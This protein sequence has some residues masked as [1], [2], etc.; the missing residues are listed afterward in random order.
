MIWSNARKITFRD[1]KAHLIGTVYETDAKRQLRRPLLDA[2]DVHKS[3]VNYGTVPETEEEHS[4]VVK[5]YKDIL[6]L[7]DEAFEAIP[8]KV[9]RHA[10]VK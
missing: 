8:A 6:D 3:N 10:E 1:V 5:W 2:Y 4:K 9:Q 7:K